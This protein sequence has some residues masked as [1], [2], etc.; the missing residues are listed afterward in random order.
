M[1]FFKAYEM[2]TA[3]RARLS[4]RKVRHSSSMR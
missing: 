4:G 3:L 1:M 2:L